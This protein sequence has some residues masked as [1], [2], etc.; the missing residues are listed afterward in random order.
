MSRRT[1]PIGVGA[2]AKNKNGDATNADGKHADAKDGKDNSGDNVDCRTAKCVAL[3]F[4]AGP[5]ENTDRLLDILKKEKVHAAF[6]LLGRNHVDKRPAEVKRIDAA[7]QGAEEARLHGRHPSP[8]CCPR[9]SRSRGW[10]TARRAG[11]H[12]ADPVEPDPTERTP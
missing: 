3:A 9:R 10:S 2:D 5:S 11:P 4:D 1:R 6:F 8:G 12:G 7:G